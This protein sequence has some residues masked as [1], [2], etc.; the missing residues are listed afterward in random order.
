MCYRHTAEKPWVTD[1]FR[2]IIGGVIQSDSLHGQSNKQDL[3]GLA[4]ELAKGGKHKLACCINQS[5]I[6]VPDDLVRLDAPCYNNITVES[7]DECKYSI[8]VEDIFR[9]LERINIRKASGPDEL[10]N[11]LLRD[12]AFALCD[13]LCCM[14]NTSITESVVPIIWKQANI[15]AVPKTRPSQTVENDLRPISLIPTLS[16]VFESLV[17][18][19]LLEIIHDKFDTR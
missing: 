1:E 9:K 13:P 19:W 2:R 3:D 8:S 17:G 18:K 7:F 16:K 5:L 4:N 15:I 12:F 6:R 10:P 11:W 14:F